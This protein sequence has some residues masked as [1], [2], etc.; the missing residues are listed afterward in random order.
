MGEMCGAVSG[1]V[2]A[3]G[4]FYGEDQAVAPRTRGFVHQFAERAGNLRCVDLLGLEE[5]SGGVLEH[6]NQDLK[7]QVCYGVMSTAVQVFM[8]QLKVWEEGKGD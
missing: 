2:L 6:F 1:G 7:E 5:R 3:I 4:L 8:E